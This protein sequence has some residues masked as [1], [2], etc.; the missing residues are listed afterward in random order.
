MNNTV[1]LTEH[2]ANIESHLF[3]DIFDDPYMTDVPV[4]VLPAAVSYHLHFFNKFL[5]IHWL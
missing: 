4:P 2:F 3:G 1:P 5:Y